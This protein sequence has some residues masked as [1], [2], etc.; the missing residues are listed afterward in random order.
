MLSR[1]LAGLDNE[2]MRL[3]V[4]PHVSQSSE[5]SIFTLIV[6]FTLNLAFSRRAFALIAD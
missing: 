1:V 5:L 4:Q 3:K 6:V 2:D